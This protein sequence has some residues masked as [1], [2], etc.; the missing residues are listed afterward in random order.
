MENITSRIYDI[1]WSQTDQNTLK[2][3]DNIAVFD[4]QN[5]TSIFTNTLSRGTDKDYFI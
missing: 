2:I 3:G 1:R 5:L 4:Y